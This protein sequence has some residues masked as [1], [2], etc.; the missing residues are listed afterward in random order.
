MMVRTWGPAQISEIELNFLETECPDPKWQ[1]CEVQCSNLGVSLE[2]LHEVQGGNKLVRIPD[3]HCDTL[4]IE[5]REPAT[6]PST[7]R[8]LW[9]PQFQV[10]KPFFRVVWFHV[11]VVIIG[12][13][14]SHSQWQEKGYVA[15]LG[16][17]LWVQV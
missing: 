13:E 14:P 9:G 10:V 17:S 2:L 16:P 3:L 5:S 8:A 11:S 15:D 7:S 1:T 12:V 6:S 4:S